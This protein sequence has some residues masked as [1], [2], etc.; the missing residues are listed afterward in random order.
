MKQYTMRKK[1][2]VASLFY[3]PSFVSQLAG[4]A[5]AF[6]ELGND[7]E[8]LLHPGYKS[9][10]E[11]AQIASISYYRGVSPD[12]LDSFTHVLVYNSAISNPL[13]AHGMR[14]RGCGIAYVYHEP[15]ISI[16]RAW[17]G[18]GMK[19]LA[20]LALSRVFSRLMLLSSDVVLLPSRNAWQNY[21]HRERAY[22]DCVLEVPLVFDDGFEGLE[23][24]KRT[25]FSYIGTISRAHGFDHFLA[26]MKYALK[27]GL[28]I[29]FLI[30]SRHNIPED[31][32]FRQYSTSITLRCGRPLSSDDINECY[33]RS[34]CVWNLYRL[35]TQSGVMANAFMC[36]APVIA[37]RT[38]AFM[39][40]VRDGYNGKFAEAVNH[41]QIAAAYFEIASAME[42][43]SR[44]CRQTF[45]DT[46]HY[47]SQLTRLQNILTLCRT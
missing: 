11:L 47:R 8:F 7:V 42:S 25:T 45:V 35:S 4:F 20:R 46:F 27:N 12:V 31:A 32:V 17:K 13:F 44:N 21:Q 2:C 34:Q 36:G 33:A 26:F 37:S 29:H 22:N 38:G 6:I 9:F 23:R 1:I 18:S 39:E 30:A 41:A 10:P 14:R 40:F 28:G 15:S 43:Y 5:R 3:N 19:S 24:M 16:A